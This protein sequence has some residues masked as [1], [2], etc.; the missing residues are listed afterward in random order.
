MG[1]W[2]RFV[3]RKVSGTSMQ[4]TLRPGQIV[5]GDR[6]RKPQVGDVVLLEHPETKAWI[7][8]RLTQIEG[9]NYWVEGDAH[10]S[11]TAS[12]STDSWVFGPVTR[13]LIRAVV[14]YPRKAKRRTS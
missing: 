5:V 3:I 13:E 2:R 7:I 6:S 9:A 12:S 4:P 1:F 14:I 8:K 11:K 10:D